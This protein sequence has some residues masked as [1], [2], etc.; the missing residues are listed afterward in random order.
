MRRLPFLNGIRA[1]EAAAAELGVTAAAVS[2]LVRLLEQ[3]LGVTLFERAANRLALT[4]AGRV[5]RDGLT[6]IFDQLATLTE[7]MAG[8]DDSRTLTVGVGSTFAIRW[9]IPRLADFRRRAPEIDVRVATGGFTVP[10]REDWTCGISL[11][12]GEW[13]GFAVLKLFDADLLPVCA[14]HFQPR[15]KTPADLSARSLLRVAHAPEDWP[16]WL[17]AANAPRLRAAGTTFDNY[18]LAIQA[19]CD[20]LGVA[21]GIRPYVDDEIRTGR[22][23]SPFGPSVPAGRSW[24]VYYPPGREKE[25]AFAAFAQWIVEAARAPGGSGAP[26]PGPAP[27][28]TSRASASRRR[29][30]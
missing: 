4:G 12:T 22:L 6:P 3:R 21:V 26:T 14:P 19:A 20:G 29:K 18:G 7:Q 2:R 1:F 24:Y 23:V 15:P 16:R 8:R 9:L 17:E 28:T 5:Y 27:R 10:Y 30:S 25:P 13:P 11:G